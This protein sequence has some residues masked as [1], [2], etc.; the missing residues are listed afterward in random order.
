MRSNGDAH[1]YIPIDEEA[2]SV[3]TP[4]SEATSSSNN[5]G[6]ILLGES[7]LADPVPVIEDGK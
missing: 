4:P 7:A 1:G 3:E 2:S 5:N 6:S